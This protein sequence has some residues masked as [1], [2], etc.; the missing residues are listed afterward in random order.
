VAGLL[1][2]RDL[3]PV[4]AAG[5]A[6]GAGFLSAAALG[7]ADG[8][9]SWLFVL[10]AA[11]VYCALGAALL[12]RRDQSTLLWAI[13]LVLAF[14]ASAVLLE[15]VWLV[16]AWAGAVVALSLLARFEPRLDIAALAALAAVD[17]L[18]REAPPTD[19]FEAQRYPASGVPALLLVVGAAAFYAWRRERHRTA[20]ICAAAV[21][22]VFAASLAILE[23]SESLGS[24]VETTFQ[25]GHT[26][27]SALWGLV[28]LALLYVG[29]ARRQRAFQLG[30]FAL[31][32]LS[33]A[34]LFVYDLAFLSSV[35]RALSFLA[36]GA[37]LI[38][39]G[40]FYQ[41]LTAEP[42]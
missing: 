41:R 42:G 3:G 20:V 26:G 5:A 9:L 7:I 1:F 15:G 23:L 34:K 13:G 27:V 10:A 22:T 32:G 21:L 6:A 8:D 12:A 36:V 18:A 17:T 24:S 33:L 37:V 25:R 39:G 19:L 29:L 38:A 40:F 30:G 16:L 31:F 35:T 14:V 4:S 28:G 2:E 11:G